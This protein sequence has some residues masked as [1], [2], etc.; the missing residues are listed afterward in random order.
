MGVVHS[1]RLV[2][3]D[4]A[5]R[6]RWRRT[7]DRLSIPE[8]NS[9]CFL[10]FG[11]LRCSGYGYVMLEGRGVGVHRLSYCLCHGEVP[12]DAHVLH[13]CDNRVCINPDHLTLGNNADN[14]ADRVRRGR[15]ANFAGERHPQIKLTRQKVEAIRQTTG[16]NVEVAAKFGITPAYVSQIRRRKIW[17]DRPEMEGLNNGPRT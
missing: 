5:L 4:I 13:R 12:K 11:A 15:S 9:G 6:K 10:W 2:I 16:S 14:V 8:P 1:N 3:E 17:A 7:L